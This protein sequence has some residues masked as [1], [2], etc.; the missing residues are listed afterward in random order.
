MAKVIPI[1]K[2]G[3]P[4]IINNYRPISLLPVVSKVMEQILVNQLSSYFESKTLFVNNQ[5]RFRDG[6]STE[7]AALELVE[8]IIKKMDNNEVPISIFLD[9]SKAFDTL[10]H[11]ILL[12]KLK[13]YGIEGVPLQLFKSYLTTRTQFVEIDD[14]KSDRLHIATGV[15]QGSILGPLL[16]I[17]YSNDFSEASQVFNF[18]SYADDTT[19]LNSLS[20]F[21]NAQNADSD[22]LINKEL[23][24]INEWLVMNKLSL[25]IDKSKFMVFHMH[26]K[27]IEAPAP[28]ISNIIIE[29]VNEFNFLGLT[30]DTHLNWKKHSGHISNRCVRIIGILNRL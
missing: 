9:L 6:H 8:R 30:L 18:I 2:K 1:F 12:N 15:S 26:R 13:Y 23:F 4:T 7:Y 10:N 16:F 14:I 11:K 29:K 24:K 20:N 17:I 28:K 21:V 22:L 5:Y 3:N 25:N 19:L 27:H